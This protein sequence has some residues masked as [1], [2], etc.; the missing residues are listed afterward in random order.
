MP[1]L[2]TLQWRMAKKGLP[3]QHT[4]IFDFVADLPYFACSH[5]GNLHL[6]RVPRRG[7]LQHT[8]LALFGYYPW[9]CPLCL[10]VRLFRRRDLHA[11]T[12]VD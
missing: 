7:I 2:N 8:I 11:A 5:C 6:R 4:T 9:R 10:Q 3:V 12:D 1:P